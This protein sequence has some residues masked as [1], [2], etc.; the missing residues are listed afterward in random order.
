MKFLEYSSPKC[1]PTAPRTWRH[2]QL[3]LARRDLAKEAQVRLNPPLELVQPPLS[4]S[5]YQWVCL[6][7]L[8]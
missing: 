4:R 3:H 6:T 7:L 2:D 1:A 5:Y 8:L